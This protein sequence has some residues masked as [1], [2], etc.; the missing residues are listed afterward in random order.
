MRNY[1]L[2]LVLKSDL[3]EKVRA[4]FLAE[5]KKLVE[6]AKGKVETENLWGKKNLVYPLK[7]EKEGFYVYY[8]LDLP[9][10]KTASLEKKIKMKGE[11]LRHLLVRKE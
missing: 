8:A 6:E 5:I 7:R 1:E 10:G 9:Q 4:D 2:V 11:V 3:S